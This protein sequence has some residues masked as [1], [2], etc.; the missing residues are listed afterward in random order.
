[1]TISVIFCDK[2]YSTCIAITSIAT[3]TLICKKWQGK[4]K[5]GGENLF[6]ANHALYFRKVVDQFRYS[7]WGSIIYHNEPNDHYNLNNSG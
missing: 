5:N 7:Y 4:N 2:V 1:M 3:H 6:D